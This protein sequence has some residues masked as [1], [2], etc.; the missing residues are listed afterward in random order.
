MGN[1]CVLRIGGEFSC[2][3]SILVMEDCYTTWSGHVPHSL[4]I[5]CTALV[6]FH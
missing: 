6:L 4:E 3:V 2:T 1:V 5:T